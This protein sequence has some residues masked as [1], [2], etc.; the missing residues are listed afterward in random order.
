MEEKKLDI[1]SLIGFLLIGGILLWMLYMNPGAEPEVIEETATEEVVVTP[2][3]QGALAQPEA[4]Q[5]AD[6]A[7][8]ARAASRLGAFGYSATLPSAT[9]NLTQVENEVLDL[10]FSNKGGYLSEVRMKNY[11]T[12]DSIPVYLIK[13]E[14]CL[15]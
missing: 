9:E 13:G 14:K 7:A 12:F 1:N 10:R 8:V 4:I 11:K 2:G 6:S 15:L 3:E 5:E